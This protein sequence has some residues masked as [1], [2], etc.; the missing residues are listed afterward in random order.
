MASRQTGY[1]FQEVVSAI[2]LAFRERA[3]ELGEGFQEA[4]LHDAISGEAA[5]QTAGLSP[6][7]GADGERQTID[8]M[9]FARGIPFRCNPPTSVAGGNQV[10]KPRLHHDGRPN[11]AATG[12]YDGGSAVGSARRPRSPSSVK[13]SDSE[14]TQ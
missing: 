1:S 2:F 10:A 5:A 13:T 4:V 11:E 14:L 7:A 6:P 8:G 3:D 9:V 12:A